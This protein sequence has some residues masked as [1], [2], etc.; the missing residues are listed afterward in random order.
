MESPHSVDNHF[1][2]TINVQ[3]EQDPDCMLAMSLSLHNFNIFLQCGNMQY[4]PKN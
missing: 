4:N 3:S 2:P 1:P